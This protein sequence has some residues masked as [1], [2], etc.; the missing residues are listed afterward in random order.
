MINRARRFWCRIFHFHLWTATHVHPSG[1][2]GRFMW[3]RCP[4][5]QFA[6]PFKIRIPAKAPV[7]KTPA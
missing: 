7:G 3:L 2:L 5:D 1:A 4:I 6:Y